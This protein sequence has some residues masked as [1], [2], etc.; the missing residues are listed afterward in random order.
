MESTTFHNSA[1]QLLVRRPT[2]LHRDLFESC[3]FKAGSSCI[4]G[5]HFGLIAST[6]N[7]Q[8]REAF[9]EQVEEA[10]IALTPIRVMNHDWQSTNEFP[11]LSVWGFLHSASNPALRI[12]KKPNASTEFEARP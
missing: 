4:S 2:L 8:F 5:L 7:L 11:N 9:I 3:L 10:P 12:K 1:K 6:I